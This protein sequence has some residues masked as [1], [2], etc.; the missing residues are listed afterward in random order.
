MILHVL[1]VSPDIRSVASAYHQPT[2][3]ES[4]IHQPLP[5]LLQTFGS[6][7]EETTDF[8][9]QLAQYFSQQIAHTGDVLWRQ[10]DRADGLYLIESGSLRATYAYNDHRELVQETMVAGTIA[11]D[12][13]TLS[14]TSRNATVVA[15]R[16]CV[17]WKLDKE[18]LARLEEERG[19]VARRFIRI[20]L[21]G[22]SFP[23]SRVGEWMLTGGWVSL[24]VAEEQDVLSSHLIAVLS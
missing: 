22:G 19:G 23:I 10:G 24:A 4:E 6:Y 5:I 12:L 9:A 21:K 1:Q 16:E 3:F 13:S 14:D 18:G 20:V 8:F 11:G 2:L 15:E 17:L 7:S